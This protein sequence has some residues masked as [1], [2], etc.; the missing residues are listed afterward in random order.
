MMAAVLSAFSAVGPDHV[1]RRALLGLGVGPGCW[2]IKPWKFGTSRKVCCRFGPS[3]FFRL[4]FLDPRA[5]KH[6]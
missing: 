2:D 5:S 3:L 6:G 4:V 1:R